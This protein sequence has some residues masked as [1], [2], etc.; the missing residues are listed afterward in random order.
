MQ[1]CNLVNIIKVYN[2]LGECILWDTVTQ[3]VWWTDIQGA[4]LFRYW[5]ETA[6]LLSFDFQQCSLKPGPGRTGTSRGA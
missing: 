6:E 5:P 2:S 1:D 4:K 3:S